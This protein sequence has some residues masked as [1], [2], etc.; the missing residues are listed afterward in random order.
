MSAAAGSH[1][2]VSSAP[3]VVAELHVDGDHAERYSA[4]YSPT[5]IMCESVL[6]EVN[7]ASSTSGWPRRPGGKWVSGTT[8]PGSGSSVRALVLTA[9]KST[10]IVSCPPSR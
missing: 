7:L 8:T 2:Q 9:G 5:P 1:S 4:A 3:G 10:V 6:V